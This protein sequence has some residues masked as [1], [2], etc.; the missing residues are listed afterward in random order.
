MSNNNDLII[1]DQIIEEKINETL[2]NNS[3]EDFFELFSFEQSLK[4]YDLY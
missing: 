1:L 4:E 2:S 3:K